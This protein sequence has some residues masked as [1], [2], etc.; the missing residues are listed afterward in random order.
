MTAAPAPVVVVGSLNLDQ[1]CRVPALPKPG[2]TTAA[3]GLTSSPG[4]K[5]ANQAVAAARLGASVRM[6]GLLG[7][8]A[9]GRTLRAAIEAEGIDTA[10]LG[11]RP[12]VPTGAAFIF[13]DP[14]AENTIVVAGGANHELGPDDLRP[15][16]LD[17]AGVV[18]LSFEIPLPTVV[19]AARAA[20]SRGARVVLNPS[21]IRP[22]PDGL[23]RLADVL[24][25]NEHELA[26]VAERA[27]PLTGDDEIE[28]ALVGLDVPHV[29]ATLGSRGAVSRDEGGFVRWA[30]A[31]RV[32]AVDT[33]GC[34]DAFVGALAAQ[35]AARVPI[36]AA[37]EFA[38][39]VGAMAATRPALSPRTR[40]ARRSRPSVHRG[41]CARGSDRRPKR[42][43][44]RR[45]APRPRASRSRAA[46]T[47][48]RSG[49]AVDAAH[50]V[51]ALLDRGG[52]EHA[53][54]HSRR[55]VLCDSWVENDA[56]RIDAI[57][58]EGQDDVDVV[59][60]VFGGRCRSR[61]G[62]LVTITACDP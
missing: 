26:A 7:D 18:T 55:S 35:L 29:I 47:D 1:S 46:A 14:A 4:G 31:P 23:L 37:T 6:V 56:A 2:H 54:R 36:V 45:R 15:E 53:D 32:D 11:A 57:G 44:G 60:L 62:D 19:H 49:R 20:R 13:V 25:V 58:I 24:V 27:R 3:T 30:P 50:H 12:G 38:V 59:A 17:G 5:G 40:P 41:R 9:N 28:D 22:M 16:A 39:T 52:R 8:D 10:G 43:G 21:P 34:G 61:R 33:T 51:L 48:V 42:S